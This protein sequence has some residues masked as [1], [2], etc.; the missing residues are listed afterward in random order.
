MIA[1]LPGALPRKPGSATFPFFGVQP[2][3]VD[4]EGSGSQTLYGDHKRYETAYFKHFPGN[5]FRGDGCRRDKDAYYWLIAREDA[6]NV[7]GHRISAA[8]VESALFSHT[9]C[10]GAA[11]VAGENEVEGQGIYAFVTLV[12][13]IQHSEELRKSLILAVRKQMEHL[14]LLTRSNGHLDFPR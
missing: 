5:Y 3:I 14:Q 13:G 2:A 8:E 7:S 1:S 9:Q 6:I 4:D 12:E 10:T 11:V